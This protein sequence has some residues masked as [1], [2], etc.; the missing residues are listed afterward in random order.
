[1]SA[2]T[3]GS[4]ADSLQAAGDRAM[5]LGDPRSAAGLF[6]RAVDLDPGRLDIWIGLAACRRALGEP[7]AALGALERAL[8]LDPRCFP[9]LLMRGSLFESLKREKQAAVAYGHAIDVLPKDA[10]LAEPTRRAL[11]HAQEVR[12]RYTADLAGALRRELGISEAPRSPESKRLSVFIDAMAGRRK[13]YHQEPVGFHYPGLPAIEFFEREE[14]PWIEGLEARTGAILGDLLGLGAAQSPELE[15]YINY[16]D[17]MPLDQWADLNR[18]FN[19]SAYHLYREGEP[20]AA[21]CE[22]C[23]A[24]MAAL[25]QI[26]QPQ[27]QRRSPTAMFSI[28]QPGTR[29]PPHTGVANT[30]AVAHLPLIVPDNCGFRVGGDTR[31]VEKGVAWVFDDTIEHEAW[32]LSAEPRIILI[33]DVWNPRL[34]EAEREVVARLMA[35]M[36]RFNRDEDLDPA[37]PWAVGAEGRIQ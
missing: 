37:P 10:P 5:R 23:P 36:D 3:A 25:A 30:R 22:A 35:A 17:S 31:K 32:N 26:P 9:A 11:A 1:M 7:E 15:P 8:T 27:V 18:S 29:I 34:P 19:W 6:E 16:P 4:P 13:I 28:L 12:E 21:H 33:F 14:F 24:T 20:I 2:L